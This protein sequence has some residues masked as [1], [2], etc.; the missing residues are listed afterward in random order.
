MNTKK[1]K[2]IEGTIVDDNPVS[3]KTAAKAFKKGVVAAKEAAVSVAVSPV[4]LVSH[5]VYG[6]CYGL[7]Y[8]AVYSALVIGKAFPE[9]SAIHKGLHEGLETAV[10]DFD[11]KHQEV[12]VDT[13]DTDSANIINA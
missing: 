12:I 9:K 2:P 13:A 10:K 4:K 1:L 5:A 8:G 11:A 7:A 6:V 3:K